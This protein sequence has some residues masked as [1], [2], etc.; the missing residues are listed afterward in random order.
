MPEMG[1][2]LSKTPTSPDRNR[3]TFHITAPSGWLNDPN[4]IVRA[5]GRYHVLFQHNPE[6]PRH[7]NIH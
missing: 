7:A 1:P 5:D 2:S 3:P 4:G 6:A